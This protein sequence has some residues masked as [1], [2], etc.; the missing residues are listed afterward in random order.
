MESTLKDRKKSCRKTLGNKTKE[1][2][3]LKG[4]SDSM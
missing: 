1:K 2:V 4:E 3:T